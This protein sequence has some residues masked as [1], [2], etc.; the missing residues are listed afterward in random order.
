M[1]LGIHLKNGGVRNSLENVRNVVV[2][3][4]QAP[5]VSRGALANLA[6][7]DF[8]KISLFSQKAMRPI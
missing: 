2:T 6:A 7:S 1:D 4:K 3:V 8:D 5:W